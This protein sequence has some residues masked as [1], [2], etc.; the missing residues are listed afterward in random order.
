MFLPCIANAGRRL[1]GSRANVVWGLL[2][3]GMIIHLTLR[4]IKIRQSRFLPVFYLRVYGPVFLLQ[5]GGLVSLAE[6][7]QWRQKGRR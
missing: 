6:C 2:W 7:Y 4:K 1:R 3:A 5:E